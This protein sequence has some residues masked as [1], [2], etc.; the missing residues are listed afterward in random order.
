MGSGRTPRSCKMWKIL[1]QPRPREGAA[2]RQQAIEQSDFDL[3]NFRI[4]DDEGPHRRRHQLD[5]G[6][7][8]IGAGFGGTG[9]GPDGLRHTHA[10]LL[11]EDGVD[12][13]TVSERL[14]HDSIQTTLELYAHVT[15][16]MRA[17]AALRFG[18]LLGRAQGIR[19]QDGPSGAPVRV[20]Q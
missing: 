20:S 7:R 2:T 19:A 14:G 15:P 3:L 5:S 9:L 18:A 12:V 16:R 8:G 1:R 17:S 11:L 13:K 4:A 10:T 6:G